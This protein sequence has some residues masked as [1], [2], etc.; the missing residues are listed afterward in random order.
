MARFR[1]SA[2]TAS[3]GNSG[4]SDNSS[5]SSSNSSSSASPGNNNESSSA[6]SNHQTKTI[7]RNDAVVEEVLQVVDSSEV[8]EECAGEWM[9]LQDSLLVRVAVAATTALVLAYGPDAVVDMWDIIRHW[10]L[11]LELDNVF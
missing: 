6:A 9:G 2:K 3:I 1:F 5:N 11:T 10:Y 7:A 8:E 4:D